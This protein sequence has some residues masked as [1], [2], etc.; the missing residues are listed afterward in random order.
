MPYQPSRRTILGSVAATFV[1]LPLAKAQAPALAAP[2]VIEMRPGDIALQGE[3]AKT[4]AMTYDG[5]VPGPVLRMKA[6]DDVRLRFVNKLDQPTSV[7]W[8]G[9]RGVSAMD[10]IA[11]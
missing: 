11:A 6:G 9:L 4:L 5:S 2:R 3:G 7:H 1:D 10:G 8:H